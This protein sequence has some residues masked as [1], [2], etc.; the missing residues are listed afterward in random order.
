MKIIDLVC[1]LM[2]L[3]VVLVS[4]KVYLDKHHQKIKDPVSK[5]QE[6]KEPTRGVPKELCSSFE[7]MNKPTQ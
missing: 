7:C 4:G 1:T 2:L 3:I 6:K 5:I